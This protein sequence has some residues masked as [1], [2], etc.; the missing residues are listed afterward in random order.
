MAAFAG[1]AE[2]TEV[3]TGKYYLENSESEYIEIFDDQTIQF[4]NFDFTEYK[5]DLV[6]L[7]IKFDENEID[8]LWAGRLPYTYIEARK[9]LSIT[10][11][12][13]YGISFYLEDSETLSHDPKIFILRT[14]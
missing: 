8:E 13:G 10:L 3:K 12:P 11:V 4:V 9:E 2:K 6:K 1:C 7:K 5:E 14:E